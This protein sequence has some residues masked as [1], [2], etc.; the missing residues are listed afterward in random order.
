MSDL[1]TCPFCNADAVLTKCIDETDGF[2][3]SYTVR[4]PDCAVEKTEE[5]R[6]D[7]VAHWNTRTD[8]LGADVMASTDLRITTGPEI[9]PHADGWR[10]ARSINPDDPAISALLWF[11]ESDPAKLQSADVIAQLKV[12]QTANIVNGVCTSCDKPSGECWCVPF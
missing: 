9:L 4:C 2:V 3:R 5:Y 10:I 8:Q 6:A 1:K 12:Q 11:K 7:V